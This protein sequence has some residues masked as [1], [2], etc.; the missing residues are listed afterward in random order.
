[1]TP[2]QRCARI[3]DLDDTLT[4]LLKDIIDLLPDLCSIGE[5]AQLASLKETIDELEKTMQEAISFISEYQSTSTTGEFKTSCHDPDAHLLSEVVVLQ[6]ALCGSLPERAKTI[7]EEMKRLRG[8]LRVKM[9]VQVFVQVNTVA[10]QTR[11]MAEQLDEAGTLTLASYSQGNTHRLCR[12]RKAS[13]DTQAD[14]R[15]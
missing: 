1:M 4:G 12:A 6:S 8:V 10:Q 3:F 5:N 7:S 2:F 9:D 15:R 14:R 13:G 11:A